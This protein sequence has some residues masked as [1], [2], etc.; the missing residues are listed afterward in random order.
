MPHYC[1]GGACF[2]LPCRRE[3]EHVG[4]GVLATEIAI[5]AAQFGVARDQ[6][7]ERAA[8]GGLLLQRAGEAFDRRPAQS[9][10]DATERDATAF[11]R[12]HGSAQACAAV[13][14]GGIS[15]LISPFPLPFSVAGS[16]SGSVSWRPAPIASL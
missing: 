1:F 10:G 7:V 6:G 5:Q 4:G 9:C 2:S 12:R 14:A 11:G 13:S 3:R 8:L 15:T 16:A